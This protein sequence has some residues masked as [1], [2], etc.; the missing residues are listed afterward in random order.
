[1]ILPSSPRSLQNV[2]IRW[3]NRKERKERQENCLIRNKC[4]VFDDSENDSPPGLGGLGVLGGLIPFPSAVS[5]CS[6]PF[7]LGMDALVV[8]R[9][10]PPDGQAENEGGEDSQARGYAEE[11]L[12]LEPA[13][14][15]SDQIGREAS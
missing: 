12:R 11:G 3:S 15:Q 4:A 6:L 7:Q 13:F 1:L 2:H 10:E 14:E 8:R 5:G 9:E